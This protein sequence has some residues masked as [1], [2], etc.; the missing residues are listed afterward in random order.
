MCIRDS[1]GSARNIF[2]ASI[3]PGVQS[4]LP[5]RTVWF[6]GPEALFLL[7]SADVS[8]LRDAEAPGGLGSS[9][10][11]EFDFGNRGCR[12]GDC[13]IGAGG[14]LSHAGGYSGGNLW[15]IAF[16]TLLAINA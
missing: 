12:A 15:I 9:S 10:Q 5:E 8:R 14:E 7:R 6:V 3:H 13:P 4:I 2:C 11:S 16:N 1:S